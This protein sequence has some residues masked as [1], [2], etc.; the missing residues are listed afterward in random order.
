MFIDYNTHW[1]F[2]CIDGEHVTMPID[3]KYCVQYSWIWTILVRVMKGYNTST[4]IRSG[5]TY[6]GSIVNHVLTGK[7]TDGIVHDNAAHG[8]QVSGSFTI[9]GNAFATYVL[10]IGNDN[11]YNLLGRQEV[12]DDNTHVECDT[13]QLIVE[14]ENISIYD[15]SPTRW[16]G[17]GVSTD[18]F[19]PC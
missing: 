19:K 13:A 17:R 9:R 2:T 15:I 6:Y 11:A 18:G 4:T 5:N 3:G 1:L 10:S 14:F 8:N 7:H 16:D 12:H